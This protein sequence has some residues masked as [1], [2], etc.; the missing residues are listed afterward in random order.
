MQQLDDKLAAPVK[1][2]PA[3]TVPRTKQAA[4]PVP[5]VHHS[6]TQA[7]STAEDVKRSD[8][9]T[10]AAAE[11]H[12][13]VHK[14]K[15]WLQMGGGIATALGILMIILYF[16]WQQSL[17]LGHDY[18]RVNLEDESGDGDIIKEMAVL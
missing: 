2:L 5:K 14:Q 9:R 18:H 6:Q 15:L 10:K 8:E 4:S 13:H 1:G 3:K 17:A 7:L 16:C 12:R 11:L